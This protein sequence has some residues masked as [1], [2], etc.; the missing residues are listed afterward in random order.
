MPA[1]CYC[2]PITSAMKPWR[3]NRSTRRRHKRA[4]TAA[5][6][7]PR[8]EVADALI[9]QR[10]AGGTA[11]LFAQDLFCRSN[12]QIDGGGPHLVDGLAFGARDLLLGQPGAPF[13]R[14]LER[15]PRVGGERLRLL[16]RLADNRLGFLADQAMLALIIGEQG[17]RLLAHAPRF[18]ELLADRLGAVIERFADQRRHLVVDEHQQKHDERHR[19]PELGQKQHRLASYSAACRLIRAFC[20]SSLLTSRPLSRATMAPASSPAMSLTP[21]SAVALVWAMRRSASASL[22]AISASTVP[23]SFS[24]SVTSVSRI[25]LTM[26]WA[27]PRASANAR[28]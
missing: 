9:D 26:V 15:A 1:W 27:L 28:S 5:S 4:A 7:E 22:T 21:A 24:I 23:R 18:V 2:L 16:A 20:T 11:R 6:V 19:D 14:F 13:Q 10:R 25:P 12:R 3:A 8:L 17:L